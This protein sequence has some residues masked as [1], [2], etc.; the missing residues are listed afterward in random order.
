LTYFQAYFIF[1]LSTLGNT[2]ERITEE[3]MKK[4]SFL[5][6]CAVAAALIFTGCSKK[7][8]GAAAAGGGRAFR[9]HSGVAG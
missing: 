3:K 2:Y 9:Q 7:A 1:Y 6:I 4:L 5:A 8:G